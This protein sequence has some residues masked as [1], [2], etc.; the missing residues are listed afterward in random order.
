MIPGLPYIVAYE[1]ERTP[2]GQERV[3]ILHVIHDTRNWPPE[4]WPQS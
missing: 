4:E 3:V 2:G 1:L